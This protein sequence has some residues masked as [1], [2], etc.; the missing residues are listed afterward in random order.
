MNTL[1]ALHFIPTFH[2]DIAYL[3]PESWYTATAVRILDR[4][5]SL[6][7]QDENY[8]F[9]VEQ[10]YFF[11]E[12]WKMHPDKQSTL[13]TL[14]EKGQ[15]HFAPGFW[16][17]PDMSMLSGESLYMQA[18][19]GRKIL[20]ETVG[21]VP[22][23][24]F[25][26]DCWGHSAAL[27]QIIRQCGYDTYTFSRCM[28]KSFD[29]ENFRWRGIDGTELNAHWMST[30]Y[31]GLSFPDTVPAVNAEE[32]HWENASADG[33]RR[34]AA[35]NAEHCGEDSQIMPVGGDMRMPSPA[36]PAIVRELQKRD[37]LPALG[38]SSFEKAFAD[39]D[40]AS[41]PVYEG[42]FI[43]SLKGTFATNIQIKLHNRAME[44]MLY[45]LEV[46]SVLKEQDADFSEPWKT[47]LKNQ[48][49][50]ILC[51]SICDESLLQ[52]SSEYAQ[53]A[54]QLDAIRR[55]LTGGGD[56]AAFNTLNFP[57]SGI[58]CKDGTYTSY[59]GDAFAPV[60][61]SVL[62]GEE[63]SLPA[64]FENTFYSAE[65]NARGFI[66]SL[67]DKQSGTV[68]VNNPAIPFG[69]LQMQTDNGDNWVEFEYPWEEDATLYTTNVPDPYDR[70][71]LP[72]HP[73]VQIAA[74]GVERASAVSFGED[75]LVITQTG[76]L[77][78]W[79]T[80]VPFTITVTLSKNSPRI[81]YHTELDNNTKRIRIR[82]AFP[83]AQADSRIR[84]QIPYGII[85]RREGPQ[86]AQRF[87]DCSSENG[88]LALLNRGL[89]ANNTENGIM[90][91]TLFRSVAM[92]YKCQSA[93]SYNTGEHFAFDYAIV[94][95]SGRA[96]DLLWKN[97]LS[98]NTPLIET[99]APLSAW[100]VEN[101]YLSA[102]RRTENGVFLR[103]Y[104]G[105]DQAKNAV[106]TVP[107]GYTKA[108]LTDGLMCAVEAFPVSG[109]LDIQ[110]KPFEVRGILFY[111]E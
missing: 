74:N 50:D 87:M 6:M 65:I 44:S 10:A 109:R 73:K 11:D 71:S 69:S 90:M 107:A 106:I 81:E 92:E 78:Y 77:R 5:V 15:L 108:A 20:A 32:L 43:S 64:V 35:R 57:V 60:H 47:T 14:C 98:F 111:K 83:L 4:A 42:E 24:A 76:H 25:I 59:A 17:V 16:A 72:T 37:D 29:I 110:L 66:T 40:F 28:E 102:M 22:K 46:L 38:F 96:D 68:L 55:E 31:A 36:A 1:T 7:E 48:F 104:A 33:I 8:T 18:Y 82:A 62:H 19:Y 75:G 99:D 56:T 95:H 2:H 54:G 97:A 84:Y 26:A 45:A 53:C 89:P 13:R 21:Y 93:L 61:E 3:R 34:L 52:V 100:K 70:R 49:H 39:I 9:T 67:T 105:T 86:P 12:Y 79:I 103:L 51:G 41:K 91:L 94:P 30:A 85:E 101:A 63:I 23:T 27:P 58:R 80:D 88:G